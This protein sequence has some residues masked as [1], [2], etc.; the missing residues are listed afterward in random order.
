MNYVQGMGKALGC[1]PGPVGAN[2]N[3]NHENSKLGFYFCAEVGP[4]L[5][6]YKAS[7]CQGR[8]FC[9]AERGVERAEALHLSSAVSV[10]TNECF[11]RHMDPA[12]QTR[13]FLF[14]E[15]L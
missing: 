13:T 15:P 10:L 5:Y 8:S 12:T 3:E 6:T 11:L 14:L 9:Q 2:N 4:E 1:S 7:P